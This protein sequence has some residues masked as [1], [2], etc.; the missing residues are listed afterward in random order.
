MERE[1]VQCVVKVTCDGKVGGEVHVR[2]VNLVMEEDES[3]YGGHRW[4]TAEWEGGCGDSAKRDGV[5]RQKSNEE[6]QGVLCGGGGSN[7]L[8]VISITG[9]Q[10]SEGTHSSVQRHVEDG[11]RNLNF[12]TKPN[13]SAY[14]FVGVRITTFGASKSLEKERQRG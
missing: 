5:W 7:S 4:T 14:E 9:D 1:R 13:D 11:E 3:G 6:V 2:E 12:P 10:H 8:N